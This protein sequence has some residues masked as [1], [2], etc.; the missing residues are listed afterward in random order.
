MATAPTDIAGKPKKLTQ[1][2]QN[3]LIVADAGDLISRQL[4]DLIA[5]VEKTKGSEKATLT[6]TIAYVPG[7]AGTKSRIETKCKL[8]T[9]GGGVANIVVLTQKSGGGLQLEMFES[10]D[11]D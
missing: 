4:P 10:T 2:R 8:A 7:S 9:P 11:D 3:D 6:L 5:A 1:K